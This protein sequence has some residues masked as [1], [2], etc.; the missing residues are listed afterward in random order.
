MG[1]KAMLAAIWIKDDKY[2]DGDQSY[3]SSHMDQ[4]WQVTSRLTAWNKQAWYFHVSGGF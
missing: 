4:G 3:V 2:Q 1:T